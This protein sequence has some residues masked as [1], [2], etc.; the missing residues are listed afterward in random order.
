MATA[1]YLLNHTKREFLDLGKQCA[2]QPPAT[3][4]VF[5]RVG[6]KQR[7]SN[8]QIISYL[9]ARLGDDM[10]W[11]SDVEHELDFFDSYT[12]QTPLS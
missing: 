11:V 8:A 4:P 5:F 7:T 12:E 9:M 3:E 2:P 6:D 1:Y 10:Q